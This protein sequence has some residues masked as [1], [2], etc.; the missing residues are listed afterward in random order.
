MA[1]PEFFE[2]LG[3]LADFVV[4]EPCRDISLRQSR[5][6][7]AA[8]EADFLEEFMRPGNGMRR[9]QNVVERKERML[10]HRF[11]GKHIHS[12]TGDLSRLQRRF[13]RTLVHNT[14][15]R[16]V[17]QIRLRLHQRQFI[18]PQQASRLVV[19]RTSDNDIV[20]SPQ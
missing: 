11:R 19:E 9:Q 13:Q 4:D 6:L 8:H 1:T 3:T 12:G 7:L 20:R 14:A 16:S 2:K 10:E 5:R 15:A 17:H 18:G